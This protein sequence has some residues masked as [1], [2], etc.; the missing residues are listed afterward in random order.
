MT[1]SLTTGEERAQ[2]QKHLKDH[3]PTVLLVDDQALVGEAV[4]RM[5]QPER[6]IV[7]HYCQDATQALRIA[8]E[9]H[10]TVILQDLVMP[11]IDGLSLV[12]YYRA[13]R[14][15]KDIPLI[16]LS[17]KEEAVT[18]AEAF[19]AGANDYL[20]KLPDRIEL[21][22]RIRYHSKGYISLLQRN[23][24]LGQ[25]ES[26]LAE[27]AG[28]VKS[29]LPPPV[30][31][32]RV[33]TNWRYVPSTVLGGDIF[34]YHW[35]DQHSFAMYLLDVCGHGV[36]AALLSVS[37]ANSIR[38]QSL[39][40]VD[41]R[42]PDQVLSALNERYQMD[43]HNQMYFTLWYGVWEPESKILSYANGGHPAPFFVPSSCSTIGEVVHCAGQNV[44]V[45]AM[46]DT[47]YTLRQ[48]RLEG[49]GELYLFSDGVYEI[50]VPDGG[51]W[52]ADNML[53]FMLGTPPAERMDRLHE[54]CRRLQGSDKLEDDFSIL[55]VHLPGGK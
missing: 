55:E 12:K 37:A 2:I 16:V 20:V 10:P 8:Q 35:I 45:G 29:L 50:E 51:I 6:D 18:K 49:P 17:T 1:A 40:N 38:S 11:E 36:G 28:Y 24:A 34:G 41:F 31:D 54:E 30:D 52:G 14:G 21:V 32:G 3:T 23:E 42:K 9:I 47:G 19:A 26:E 7:F 53:Q 4:R 46:P 15:T 27:A 25:L 22:A 39:P 48:V 13:A 43:D 5:L 33:R 44:I